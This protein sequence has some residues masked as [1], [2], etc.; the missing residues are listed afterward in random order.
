MKYSQSRPGF[1]LVS[2][3]PFPTTITITPQ[4]PPL[5]IN[6]LVTVPRT[7]V[8]AG[9]TITFMFHI[10]SVL[11][12]GFGTYMSF[13]FLSVL[14]SS[15]PERQL[16]Y[17]L[18]TITRSGRLAKIRWFDCI[19][20]SQRVLVCIIFLD[21]FW[22]VHIRFDLM[23]KFLAQFSVDHFD[24]PIVSCLILFLH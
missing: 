22:V 3:C 9:I 16:L 19:S 13:R 14:P 18:L 5:V 7:P 10:F 23:V 1:E 17:L 8:S 11:K 15:Q 24:H 2:P 12:Q 21:G 4:A 20:K 6:H